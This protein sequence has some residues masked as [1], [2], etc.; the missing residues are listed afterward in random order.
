MTHL[1]QAQLETM[2]FKKLGKNVKISDKA[3][4]YYPDQMEIGD[5]SRIDDF[6]VIS[7]NIRIGAYV[8]IAAF[9]LLAGGKEGIVLEDF[10]GIAYHSQIFTE[11]DDYTGMAMVS[12][13]IPEKFKKVC[14]AAVTVSRHV[15]IGGNAVI[16]PGVHIAEGCSIGAMTLVTKSTTPWGIYFGIPA[17]RIREK[18]RNV[19]EVEKQFNAELSSHSTSA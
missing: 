18:N 14:R 19:L 7:G 3:T 15:I 4:I 2:N 6:C 1:S 12:P 9:C 17:K 5:H 8:H 10:S 16:F 11:S 13:L